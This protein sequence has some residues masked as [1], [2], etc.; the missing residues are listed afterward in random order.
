MRKQIILLLAACLILSSGAISLPNTHALA[1]IESDSTHIPFPA[2]DDPIP[3]QPPGAPL[4]TIALSTNHGKGGQVVIVSGQGV[5]PYPGVRVAWLLSDA[6]MTAAV[7]TVSAGNAYSATLT[8]PDT[9]TP[10]P[11]RICAAVTGTPLAAFACANFTVDPIAPGSVQGQVPI[12]T[13]ALNVSAPQVLNAVVNLYDQQ[14]KVIGSG[15]IQNNGSFAIGSVPPGTYTAGVA[16]IVPVLVET[17]SV[18]VNSAQLS[19]VSFTPFT[20][21]LAASVVGVRMTPTGKPTTQ[22][23]FGTYLSYRPYSPDPKPFFDADLQIVSGANVSVVGFKITDPNGSTGAIGAPSAPV[24]STTYRITRTVGDFLP[25]INLL[26]IEPSGTYFPGGQN[27]STMR[28]A[29][30]RVNVIQHPMTPNTLQYNVDRRVQDVKW[31]GSRY[32]FNTRIPGN[33]NDFDIISPAP[34]YLS[35]TKLLPTTFPFPIPSLQYLGKAENTHG[36]AF[37]ITGTLDLDGNVA[38][39]AVRGRAGAIGMSQRTIDDVRSFIPEGGAGIPPLSTV[40]TLLE[41][42]QPLGLLAPAAFPPTFSELRQLHFDFEPDPLF[43]FDEEAPVYEGLLFS[44]FGLVNVRMSIILG[45]S[46]ELVVRGTIR[47]LAPQMDAIA[48]ANIRPH[49]DVDIIADA[50]FG[51]ASVG[52]TA[53][54]E[55]TL[56]FP[57]RMNTQDSRV[58]W[59]E[60]PCMR[61]KVILYLWA[62]VSVGFASKQWNLKPETL[63]DYTKGTCPAL[64]TASNILT[65]DTLP[66]PPRLL[67]AP[68]VASG[69]GGRMLSVYVEDSTPGAATPAPKV[70]ARFWD[71]PNGQWGPAVALTDG[72]HMVQDPV[73]AFFGLGGSAIAVWSETVITPAQEQAAG[74]NLNAVLSRQEI[75][76]KVWNGTQWGQP[77]RLTNDLLPDGRA[78]LAGDELGATL[79]WV[80]DADGALTTHLDW[81]IAVQDWNAAGSLSGAMMVLSTTVNSMAS[82]VSV[83]RSSSAGVS[84]RALAWITDLDGEIA[85][86]G[87]RSIAIADWN[88]AK[89][90]VAV[91]SIAVLVR[92]PDS[93]SVALVPGSQDVYLTFVER[94]K[95]L[96]G[97]DSGPGNHG[98][99]WSARRTGSTWQSVAISDDKNQLVRA[100]RPQLSVSTSG[101]PLLLFRRFGQVGTNAELGQLALIRL[102][103]NGSASF[104]L[105]LTDEARQHWQQAIAINTSTNQAVV[106]SVGRTPSGGAQTTAALTAMKPAESGAHPAL[107]T[108]VLAATTDPITSTIVEAGADPALDPILSLSVPH[109]AP[110]ANVVVTATLHNLGRATATGLTVNLYSGEPLSGTLIRTKS[111]ANMGFNSASKVTFTVTTTAGTQPIYAHVVTTGTNVS[112]ANDIATAN[113]G[114]LL[115]PT[116]VVAALSPRF[117]NALEI[118]WQPPAISGIAGYRILRKQTPGG[119]FELAGEATGTLYVDLLLQRGIVYTYTV[120]SYDASGVISGFSEETTGIVPHRVYLPLIRR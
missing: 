95:D 42:A 29:T 65:P 34:Y 59:L 117:A 19:S 30:R 24:V 78:S 96:S 80:R 106:L 83:A 15:P 56:S 77:T 41:Q 11:A 61:L 62:R 114:A 120:Q 72:S 22:F 97:T 10:G 23:D 90:V 76:Y 100:E 44:A 50:L 115:P 102:T 103:S 32:V 79:A 5:A 53:H 81:R 26:K 111:V 36:A 17:K 9:A 92:A 88:G 25:G 45:V 6:T 40:S 14:G 48:T 64:R 108:A 54:T 49:V 75:F 91:P 118:A 13:T 18:V 84:R 63:V 12:T 38:F 39:T 60:D 16:G 94:R 7:A 55:A 4:P 82:Q 31:N 37:T 74:N 110:G 3:S 68:A 101:E 85:T 52:A 69:P 87:D 20:Q 47:P 104:P 28:S 71:I 113:L 67:A 2:P 8:V 46:G 70:M 1:P 73:A 86:G 43:P 21:C 93:P 57:A 105:Y 119:P 99:L 27:C 109:A 35:G 98:T 107:K 58:V 112:T 66:Q 116:L 89:W 33:Y 51:V